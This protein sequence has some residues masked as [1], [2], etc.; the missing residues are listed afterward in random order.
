M[1]KL[2]VDAIIVP[3]GLDLNEH[4]GRR[5]RRPT[6]M[7]VI[8][9]VQPTKDRVNHRWCHLMASGAPAAPPTVPPCAPHLVDK[10]ILGA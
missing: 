10:S 3:A 5:Q 2:I 4:V 8:A 6:A 1:Y 9:A 7:G